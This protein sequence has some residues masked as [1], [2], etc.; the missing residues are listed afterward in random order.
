VPESHRVVLQPL[1][2]APFWSLFPGCPGG[3]PS[4]TI[5][6]GTVAGSGRL[7]GNLTRCG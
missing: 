5:T 2:H 7:A 4:R 1:D 3:I 6:I